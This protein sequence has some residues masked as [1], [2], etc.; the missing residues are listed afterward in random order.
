MCESSVADEAVCIDDHFDIFACFVVFHRLKG[1]RGENL[2]VSREVMHLPKDR[3]PCRSISSAV[4]SPGW[5]LSQR[6]IGY[7]LVGTR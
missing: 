1:T 6:R 3:V 5:S 4:E 2:L 7:S